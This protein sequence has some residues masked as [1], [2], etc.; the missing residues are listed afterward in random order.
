MNVAI[1]TDSTSD[2]PAELTRSRSITVVPLTLN[3]EGK[4][5]LDGV[6]I[7]PDEFYRRLPSATTHPTTSQPSPGRFAEAYASLLAEHDAVVSIHISEKLSGTYASALQAKDMTDPKRVRVIDSELVSM[8]LGLI[9]L[10]ASALA[11][12]GHDA[13]A[14]E[15]KVLD[16]RSQIQTYF[17][18]ATLEFLRRGGRIGRASALLGSVLQVKP[19]LCIR[20]GLVT[21]LERVRTFDRALTRVV[22]LARA[23]DR[24]HGV[25]V[26]VG[27]ADAESDAERIGHEL[28]S[29][30]ETLMIQPLGP[31]V[32]AHAGPGVVGVGCYPAELLPLGIKPASSARSRA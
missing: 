2:L 7:Q 18:V 29:I 13:A 12:G 19:V 20:D 6:D 8:S 32:G 3:F 28:E 5:L 14:I 10:A 1:V 30:A 15:T 16:M 17:S 25:C 27:H 23:V 9:T 31:V 24:G 22:E 4:T 26:I 11:A 21:P